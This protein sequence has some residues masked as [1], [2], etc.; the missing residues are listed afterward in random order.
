[1]HA[2]DTPPAHNLGVQG[3]TDRLRTVALMEETSKDDIA[4]RIRL[5]EVIYGN[6]R[7]LSLFGLIAA[8]ITLAV[9]WKTAE[10]NV[11]LSWLAVILL[12][13]G[14]LF[15]LVLSR[16]R[17]NFEAASASR[18]L[19]WLA[20][21]SSLAG[22]AWGMLGLEVALLG[23]PER[24]AFVV[25]AAG[26]LGAAQVSLCQGY[27][28]IVVGFTLPAMLPTAL[29][30]LTRSTETQQYAGSM[31]LAGC[32]LLIASALP[33]RRR[34]S[35]QIVLQVQLEETRSL[36]D[37]RRDQV[38]KMTVALRGFKE[39]CDSCEG[40]LRRTS[41]D[42]GLAEGKAKALAETL[43]RV[44]LVC[45]ETGLGNVRAFQETVGVEWRR[46]MRA[47]HPVAL[48]L[49]DVDEF[50][51]YRQGAQSSAVE[52]LVKR[53]AKGL[54]TYGRRA[55]DFA[56]RIDEGRF[57]LLLPNCSA[58]NALRI[59]DTFRERVAALQVPRTGSEFSDYI[60]VHVGV[61]SMVPA[62]GSDERLM[63][64]RAE[65]AGY[66][67]GFQGGNRSV[68][69]RTLDKL[70][71]EHWNPN[72]DGPLTGN[73]LQQ[74][75]LILGF[76][77]QRRL[78]E[79]GSSRADQACERETVLATLS[80]QL[81]VEIEGQSV[82]LKPGDYLHLPPGITHSLEVVGNEPCQTFEA[83]SAR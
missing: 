63:L 57:V 40:I 45:P 11:L 12:V 25:F 3:R 44:S 24:A 17:Q 4:T 35:E 8:A 42:L 52:T 20:L 69:Y 82:V 46:A 26:A 66:E 61:V 58:R 29:A 15:L 19:S 5:A 71:L 81:R 56:A 78:L 33:L 37:Q 53:I 67:A 60:T 51:S 14:S 13:Y 27:L 30:L 38:E 55:G 34:Q 68:L 74:K 31:A 75:L 9:C 64:E 36:L 83:M 32:V 6:A 54:R 39:K 62:R 16:L 23:P 28:P 80:G 79:A 10:A 49:V 65:S 22:V 48:L 21:V 70:R 43:T 2:E 18:A 1:M 59:A 76:E 7:P 77:P 72:A 73:A 50:Q 47:R 41:A